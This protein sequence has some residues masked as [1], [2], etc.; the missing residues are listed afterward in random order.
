M[1]NR[2]NKREGK[3]EEQCNLVRLQLIYADSIND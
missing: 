1:G 2:Y 3:F